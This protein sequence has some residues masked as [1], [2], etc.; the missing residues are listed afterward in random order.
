MNLAIVADV[1]LGIYLLNFIRG[2]TSNW[3]PGKRVLLDL[4]IGIVLFCIVLA[5]N[6]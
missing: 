1:M 2:G 3:T 5:T 4:I 6:N